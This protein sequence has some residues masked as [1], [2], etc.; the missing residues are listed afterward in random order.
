MQPG[1]PAPREPP[2]SRHRECCIPVGIMFNALQWL[3]AVLQ[4]VAALIPSVANEDKR[5]SF[6]DTLSQN[7]ASFPGFGLFSSFHPQDLR[8][9]YAISSSVSRSLVRMYLCDS[10]AR[11]DETQT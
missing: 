7:N 1:T 4:E 5:D 8:V 10:S 3:E 2:N 6:A 11:Q 9:L